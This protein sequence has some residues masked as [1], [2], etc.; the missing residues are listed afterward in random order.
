MIAAPRLGDARGGRR[1]PDVVFGVEG[2]ELAARD[3]GRIGGGDEACRGDVLGCLVHRVDHRLERVRPDLLAAAFG[4]AVE[5]GIE[6]EEEEVG[7]RLQGLGAAHVGAGLLDGMAHRGQRLGGRLH[8][9]GNLGI[10]LHA[11]KLA[12]DDADLE[13]GR[14]L[15][16]K[17]GIGLV[18][19]GNDEGIA[20][21]RDRDAV[22]HR[23]HVAHGLGL[24][25]V[26][27]VA[28]A[29]LVDD[30]TYRHAHARG[31]QADAAAEAGGDADRAA[32]VGAVSDGHDAGGDGSLRAAAGAAGRVALLPGVG[33]VAEH[34]ALGGGGHGVLGRGRAAQDVDARRLQHVGEVGADLHRHALAQARAEFDLA[35]LLVAEDVLDQERHAL[36][37]AVAKA[38]L[39][40]PIDAV[41]IELDHGPDGRI[42]LLLG[43]D[44]RQRQLLRAHLLLGDQLGE[45]EG[46]VGGVFGEVHGR[47]PPLNTS[48][49]L[50][51]RPGDEA[52][53]T[54]TQKSD[55]NPR[56][57]LVAPRGHRRCL[58]AALRQAQGGVLLSFLGPR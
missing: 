9:G 15:A 27:G 46:V 10:D 16:G 22:E 14:L 41:G 29:A 28:P 40:Q 39:V 1:Q 18:G 54:G 26:G 35:S 24:H 25:E 36:E 58:P 8:G 50:S 55:L 44:G 11:G 52:R 30:G 43:G 56:G 34:G 17:R 19:L 3:V 21:L 53:R 47:T 31:F 48:I 32:D 13:P 37:R 45:A 6:A 12:Q 51:S 4:V 2:R 33:G 57:E 38:L 23:R 20:R 7:G 42:D 5:A 49:A